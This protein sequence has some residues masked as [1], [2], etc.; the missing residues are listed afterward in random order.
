MT[1]GGGRWCARSCPRRVTHG[2][3]GVR[4]ARS[5]IHKLVSRVAISA[6]RAVSETGTISTVALFSFPEP[7]L[8]SYP[9]SL[10]RLLL[11]EIDV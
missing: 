4:R 6:R 3:I 1:G 8:W 11:K 7:V 10:R 9:A 5:G 2:R